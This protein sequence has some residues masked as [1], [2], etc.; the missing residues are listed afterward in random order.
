M[1]VYNIVAQVCAIR[2][3]ERDPAGVGEMYSPPDQSLTDVYWNWRRTDD[4][5]KT[6]EEPFCAKPY[7]CVST[8]IDVTPGTWKSNKE[9]LESQANLLRNGRKKPPK[10]AS[11]CKQHS[12]AKASFARSATGSI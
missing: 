1:P 12:L 9:C 8:L 6:T 2:P 5:Y 7:L 3:P 10:Q 11:T 4:E